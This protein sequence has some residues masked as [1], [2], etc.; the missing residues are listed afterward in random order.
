MRIIL[1]LF[2]INH[3]LYS[4]SNE[5]LT[6]FSHY[7]K[8]IDNP[9]DL[10]KIPCT[11]WV[12]ISSMAKNENEYGGLYAINTITEKIIPLNATIENDKRYAPH[13]IY[14]KE[15]NKSNFRLYVINH[16]STEKI[17]IYNLTLVNEKP[18]LTWVQSIIFPENVW[19]NGLVTDKEG[20][21]YATN[22]YNS[23]DRNFLEKFQKT[24]P[25]GQI[26]KWNSISGW[27]A[28]SSKSFSA[29]NG[30]AISPTYD[31]LIISEW[32]SK[33]IYKM[34]LDKLELTSI[35]IDFLPDNIRWTNDGLLLITGQKGLPHKV[36][37]SK[38]INAENMYFKV[39]KLNPELLTYQKLID[40]GN[41]KFANG[42]VT[43]EVGN[44]YWI[45]CVQNNKIAVYTKNR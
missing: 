27:Q 19:A 4:Q 40:G 22:M 32:A 5:N 7:I 36:F 45:G 17:E 24:L 21:I 9:E 20:N 14:L 29:A 8:Q 12:I 18:N 33:T 44:S 43:I 10:V 26:W 6:S 15:L 34:S 35:K 1:I 39:I 30:I 38:G 41:Q 23:N 31:Y 25:T 11:N 16:A 28:L 13:G 2:A 42:T 37:T 3:C